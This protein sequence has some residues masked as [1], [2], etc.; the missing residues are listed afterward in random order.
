[1]TALLSKKTAENKNNYEVKD[2]NIESVTLSSDKR[3]VTI[4]LE[5]NGSVMEN[6]KETEL[7][8]K[9]V[10][11]EDGSKTFNE[12]KKFTP[13]DVKTPEIKEVVGLGTKAFKIVFS[14]PVKR[15]DAVASS[16][17]KVDA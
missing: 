4:L 10:R 3:S 12:T 8:V 17:Y 5:E 16:N 9:N 1:M 14:E 7:K 2:M 15:G 11:N 6:Q 13:V